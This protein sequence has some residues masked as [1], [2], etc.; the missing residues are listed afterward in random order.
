MLFGIAPAL[1]PHPDHTFWGDDIANLIDDLDT[2]TAVGIGRT[3]KTKNGSHTHSVTITPEAISVINAFCNDYDTTDERD[4]IER[5]TAAQ[6][7]AHLRNARFNIASFQLPDPC[8]ELPPDDVN[9]YCDGSEI[10]GSHHDYS[11]AAA[12]VWIPADANPDHGANM[13]NHALN[14][15]GNTSTDMEGTATAIAFGGTGQ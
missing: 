6:I 12:G 1:T 4:R 7:V 5:T 2:Q 13:H 14:Q 10:N 11:L 8:N 9:I 15:L 3:I